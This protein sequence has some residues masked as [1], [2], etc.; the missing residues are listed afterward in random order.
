MVLPSSPCKASPGHLRRPF[1]LLI[2]RIGHLNSWS[3]RILTTLLTPAKAQHSGRPKYLCLVG[4]SRLAKVER[5]GVV[6]PCQQRGSHRGG[7]DSKEPTREMYWK[8]VAGKELARTIKY[9]SKKNNQLCMSNQEL[10]TELPVV[11][12][13]TTPKGIFDPN[14]QTPSCA[15]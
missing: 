3:A 1:P 9:C 7:F 10:A 4:P 5:A 12:C 2:G 6:E 14:L 13:Y 15:S 11:D 8:L